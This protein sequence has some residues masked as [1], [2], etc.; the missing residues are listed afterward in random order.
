MLGNHLQHL[1]G[2]EVEG[3]DGFSVIE[4]RVCI[5]PVRINWKERIK[6][7]GGPEA[8]LSQ[9]HQRLQPLARGGR[10]GFNLAC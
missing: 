10:A 6:A 9:G 8:V 3:F 4:V 5:V 1:P 2:K 7:Y